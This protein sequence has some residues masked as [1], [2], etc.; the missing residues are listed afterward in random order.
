LEEKSTIRGFFK[1]KTEI[2]LG[3]KLTVRNLKRNSVNIVRRDQIPVSKNQNVKVLIE[4]I[5]PKPEKQEEERQR[6]FFTWRLVLKPGEK[7]VITVKYVIR[8]PKDAVLKEW[9]GE[10]D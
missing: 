1:R 5:D 6:G 3:Y 8:H 9:Q 10:I 4:E 2:P 7:K